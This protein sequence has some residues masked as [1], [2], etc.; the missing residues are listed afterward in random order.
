[1]LLFATTKNYGI[2]FKG[3][4]HV[5]KLNRCHHLVENHYLVTFSL[6]HLPVPTE[7]ANSAP[8]QQ[9]KVA[10]KLF[11]ILSLTVSAVVAG[12]QGR[13]EIEEFGL[14]WLRKCIP[15]EN[16]IPRHDTI[17]RVISRT[18]MTQFQESVSNW[19]KTCCQ[20]PS[21]LIQFFYKHVYYQKFWPMLAPITRFSDIT[22]IV[23]RLR[24]PQKIKQKVRTATTSRVGTIMS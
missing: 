11:D 4:Q 13:E 5:E 23:S 18:N 24:I 3:K 8:R 20:W 12:S 1:M 19:V 9:G 14:D 22:H 10:H 7:V 16:G 15:L 6:V 17:A 21:V 2:E